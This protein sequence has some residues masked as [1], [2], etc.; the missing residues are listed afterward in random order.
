[1]SIITE[2]K[3]LDECTFSSET[4]LSQ[5]YGIIEVGIHIKKGD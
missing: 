3:Y 4:P 1:M 5:E 2:N